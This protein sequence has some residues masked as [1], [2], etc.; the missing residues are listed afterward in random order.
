VTLSDEAL[1]S[2]AKAGD[3]AAFDALVRR[4]KNAIQG[5]CRRYLGNADDAYD[6][7]QDA[8]AAAWLGLARYDPS[9]AFGP[10]LRTIALNKCRDFGRRRSV[11]RLLLSAFRREPAPATEPRESAE[12]DDR[13][14]ARLDKEIAALPS[15]YKEVLILTAL[16]GLSH[17]QAAEELGLS[18]KAVEMRVYRAKKRLAERM[19]ET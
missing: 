12:T 6:V 10:W 13:R 15:A 16:G 2:E 7:L 18:A 17:Q 5:L 11:R 19:K 3:R 9:R 4:H 1:A 8:F 14:L